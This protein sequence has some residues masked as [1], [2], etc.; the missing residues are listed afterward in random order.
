MS[1]FSKI[2]LSNKLTILRLIL[3]IPFIFFFDMG[4]SY[5]NIFIVFFGRIFALSIFVAAIMTDYFDGKIARET[6]TVTDFGKIMDPIADKLL[7]FSCMFVLLKH[8]LISLIFVLIIL[9][10]EFIVTAERAL[11][12]SRGAGAIPASS[13]GKYK[14]VA[15]YIALSI[16]ILLPN[17][18]GVKLIISILLI[19]AVVLTVISGIE[20]HSEAKKYFS[21]EI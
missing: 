9:T 18:W 20:Y 1:D 17:V 6:G 10:R 14:T 4:L 7:T 12:A 15:T 13:L 8:D 11:A 16:A 3:I 19:P 5:S 21:D 2:N